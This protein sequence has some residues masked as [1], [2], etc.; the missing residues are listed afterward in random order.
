MN[1]GACAL[2]SRHTKEHR[3]KHLLENTC[4]GQRGTQWRQRERGTRIKMDGANRMLIE[5]SFIFSLYQFGEVTRGHSVARRSDRSSVYIEQN[6]T[7]ST[8][9]FFSGERMKCS[10]AMCERSRAWKY[11][12]SDIYARIFGFFC[13]SPPQ[14]P[15]LIFSITM[16]IVASLM[17]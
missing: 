1:E 10:I 6:R 2:Y 5:R 12:C 7:S 11:V 16:H 4:V 17:S 3:H 13:D 9:V 15:H 14:H 8:G